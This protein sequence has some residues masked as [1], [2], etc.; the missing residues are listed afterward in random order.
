MIMKSVVSN[1][2]S[3]KKSSKVSEFLGSSGLL[4]VGMHFGSFWA[5]LELQYMVVHMH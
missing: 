3:K 2:S 1:K 5:C 4:M